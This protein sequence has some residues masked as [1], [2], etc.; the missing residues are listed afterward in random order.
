MIKDILY[1]F[2]T[3]YFKFSVFFTL[4]TDLNLGQLHAA[5]HHSEQQS[6]KLSLSH[7]PAFSLGWFSLLVDL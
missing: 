6:S 4:S 5:R 1:I 7:L 2:A 3:K